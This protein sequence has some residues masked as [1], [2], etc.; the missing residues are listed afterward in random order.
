MKNKILITFYIFVFSLMLFNKVEA[1]EVESTGDSFT[2]LS[3]SYEKDEKFVYSLRANFIHGQAAGL[4]FGASE[5]EYYYVLNMDRYEN[6]VKLIYFEKKDEGEGY[7]ATEL[8]RDYFIGNDKMT[9]AE[10]DSVFPKVRNVENV[11]LIDIEII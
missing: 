3:E 11:D 7:N 1:E 8:Y 4:V 5:D 6:A 10:R 2:L 9:Q